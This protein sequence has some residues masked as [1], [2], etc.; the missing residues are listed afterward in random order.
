MHAVAHRHEPIGVDDDLDGVRAAGRCGRD[1]VRFRPDRTA[2]ACRALRGAGCGLR[3]GAGSP[4]S[5]RRRTGPPAQPGSHR[6]RGDRPDAIQPGSEH[7]RP[8]QVP[9]G[10]QQLVPPVLQVPFQAGEHVQ[11]GSDL[12][13][14]G[15]RQVR[16]SSRTQRGGAPPGAQRAPRS[17][18]GRPGGRRPRG[19]AA[20]TPCARNEDRDTA[21][22]APGTPGCDQA[23]PSIPGADHRASSR[24][25]CRESVLSVLAC[26]LRPRAAAVSAGSATCAATPA[27]ASSS[28]TYRHP[29]HPSSANATSS[30]PANRASQARI[31]TRS[32][33]A[34]WPRLTFPV[35]VLR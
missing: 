22:A 4:P 1:G 14:P 28:A 10:N 2:G 30:R 9:G 35:T 23:G 8:G 18:A 25:R 32:A 34:I 26:R 21:P 5:G 24:R 7:P 33:G 13:L 3:A 19:R 11:G 31:C 29:V 27:A 17:A 16:R 15:R 20:P 12:R 6:Q